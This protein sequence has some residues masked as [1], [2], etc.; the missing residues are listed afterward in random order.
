MSVR[1]RA[2]ILVVDDDE[3][4]QVYFQ[5]AL[6]MEGYSVALASTV[7]MGLQLLQSASPKFH[8]LVTDIRLPDGSGLELVAQAREAFNQYELGILVMSG[9]VSKADQEKIEGLNAAWRQKPVQDLV[10]AV[11]ETLQKRASDGSP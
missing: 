4:M 9:D 6:E 1:E 2:R 11:Q 7:A 3:V 8:G 10:V 5:I